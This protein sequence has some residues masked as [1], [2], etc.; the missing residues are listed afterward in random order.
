[1]TIMM[2]EKSITEFWSKSQAPHVEVGIGIDVG[3][4]LKSGRGVV[5][6]PDLRTYQGSNTIKY[7]SNTKGERNIDKS[8]TPASKVRSNVD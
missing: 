7:Y 8:V 3:G 1:M 4:E 2:P 5:Q 6:L